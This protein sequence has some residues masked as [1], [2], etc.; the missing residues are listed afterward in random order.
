M[1]STWLARRA[2]AP[3]PH[4]ELRG[5]VMLAATNESV[6][7]LNDA[8]QAV[9]GALGEL[10]PGRDYD[11]AG[12]RGV[13]LH[14][15][16]HV[17][18]RINDRSEQLHRGPA[19]L[20]GYRGVVEAIAADGRLT[21][22]WQTDGPDGAQ[23]H[24]AV[25]DADYVARGGVE[26]GYAMTI[27]KAQGLTVDGRWSGPDGTE[28]AGTVLVHAPGADNPALYVALSRHKDQ[29]LLFGSRQ[30]LE[31]SQDVHVQGQPRD[32][33]D[34]LR[35][36][37]E[38]L[39]EQARS[40]ETSADDRPVLDD[41]GHQPRSDPP[42]PHHPPP[43]PPGSDRPGKDIAGRQGERA[44][45]GAARTAARR[46]A[47]RARSP[48]AAASWPSD[49]RTE[50]SGGRPQWSDPGRPETPGSWSVPEHRSASERGAG[51][52]HDDDPCSGERGL[53]WSGGEYPLARP[54][55]D[56]VER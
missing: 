25:L 55:R 17:M 33:L 16:D 53:G 11:L 42:D 8:A 12:G 14:E 3:D 13:R 49:P 35:R 45:R 6:E 27:H 4:T 40:T 10:G 29:V 15:G 22:T 37:V 54:D 26:R 31:T 51:R 36:V 50:R 9:R 32:D 28:Q 23:R 5:L 1:V 38:Q 48:A 24:Q 52:G 20:N 18:L 44:R 30:E 39:A 47:E 21:V 2:G 34:R 19:V 41:L 46:I 43:D 7:R 56:D